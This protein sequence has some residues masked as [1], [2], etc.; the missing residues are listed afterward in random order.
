MCPKQMEGEEAFELLEQMFKEYHLQEYEFAFVI[1]KS[2]W[3][4]VCKENREM[5]SKIGKMDRRVA[6]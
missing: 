1:A 6:G 2:E 4:R 3:E 5:R